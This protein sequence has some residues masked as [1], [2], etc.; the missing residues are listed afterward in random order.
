[1]SAKRAVK[2]LN[3]LLNMV[4]SLSELAE[5]VEQVGSIESLVNR[6]KG[7]ADALMRQNEEATRTLEQLRKDA[8]AVTKQAADS[9]KAN[10]DAIRA[11][12]HKANVIEAEGRAGAEKILAEAKAV[13]DEAAVYMKAARDNAREEEVKA[14]RA[15]FQIEQQARAKA[16]EAEAET[17]R[18][19]EAL[20]AVRRATA[21]EE[22]KLEVVRDKISSLRA[23]LTA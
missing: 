15:A 21:E 5:E 16:A 4:K 22:R 17:L 11:A 8:A 14:K 10:E 1:M 18:A 6:L 19:K 9:R 20:E 3:A 12:A 23:Q 2:E 7:E 13:R